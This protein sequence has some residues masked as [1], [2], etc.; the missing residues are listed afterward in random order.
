MW[1]RGKR[2]RG[3]HPCPCCG[4]SDVTRAY[5]ERE[6]RKQIA[7]EIET[8]ITSVGCV[9]EIIREDGSKIIITHYGW[10]YLAPNGKVRH[11]CTCRNGGKEVND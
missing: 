8:H 4:Q 3:G 10:D 7:E 11:Q 1:M 6:V 9:E 5:E 2:R